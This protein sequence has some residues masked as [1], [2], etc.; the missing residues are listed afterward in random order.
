[1]LVSEREAGDIQRLHAL[2]AS[3]PRARQRDRY[4]MALWAIEGREKLDIARGL[5]VA[6][7]TVEGWAYRYRDLGVEG[8]TPRPQRGADP[9]IPRERQEDFKRRMLAGPLPADGVC[10]LRGRDAVRI[11]NDEYGAAYSLQGTYDLMHRLNLSSLAP[12]P[13][14][15]QNDPEAMARF[16]ERAPLLSKP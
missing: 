3:E 2:I 4:R 9:K 14:H 12:R 13:R 16:R 8:L 6:K 15:E 5:G 1:M 7:S 11:L 10:T